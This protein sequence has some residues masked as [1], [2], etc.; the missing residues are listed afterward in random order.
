MIRIWTSIRALSCF[1]KSFLL[2][3]LVPLVSNAQWNAQASLD[4][5]R[6]RIGEQIT[7]TLSLQYMEREGKHRIELPRVSKILGDKIEVLERGKADTLSPH[8]KEDPEL[9]RIEQ[10]FR[11][12][13]FDSGKHRIPP[14]HFRINGDSISTD[15]LFLDVR[16]V[17][18][19]ENKKPKPIKDIRRFPYTWSAWFRDHWPWFAVGGTALLVAL[20]LFLY[21]RKRKRAPG[22]HPE[23]PPR[24]AH[25]IALEH[26]RSLEAEKA[27]QEKDPKA[28]Y[29]ELTDTLRRYLEERYRVPALESTTARILHELAFTDIDD[30]GKALLRRLLKRSDMVKFAKQKTT[31]EER[32]TS[33]KEAISFVERSIPASTESEGNSDKG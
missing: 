26:L 16:T 7:L 12:T 17:E 14:M 25:E 24:P 5:Q 19:G 22:E 15:P 2:V 10:R 11:L 4:T 9:K 32:E 23:P 21:Y 18:L 1:G 33:L 27:W 29:T 6:I 31:S 8:E 28:F 30:E 20:L 3:L 13:S